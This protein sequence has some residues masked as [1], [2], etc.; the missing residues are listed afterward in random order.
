MTEVHMAT[1]S[2]GRQRALRKARGEI[3]DEIHDPLAASQLVEG[4]RSHFQDKGYT[5]ESAAE[6][7]EAVRR[8]ARNEAGMIKIYEYPGESTPSEKPSGDGK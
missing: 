1:L 3:L 2:E 5:P 8:N 6:V 7:K 4:I